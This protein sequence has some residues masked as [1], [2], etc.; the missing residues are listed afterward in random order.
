[1]VIGRCRCKAAAAASVS[2]LLL[3]SYSGPHP[4]LRRNFVLVASKRRQRAGK[5]EKSTIACVLL[6][7][8][9]EQALFWFGGFG[10]QKDV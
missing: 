7:Y 3:S 1:M 9:L 2:G 6:L 5:K 4:L 10:A 8:S